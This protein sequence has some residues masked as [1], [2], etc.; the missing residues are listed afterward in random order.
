MNIVIVDT[1]CHAVYAALAC[2]RY[3]NY[4]NGLHRMSSFPI[5]IS[6]VSA[7]LCSRFAKE[8]IRI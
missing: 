4:F 6:F 2:S 1:Y 5:Q 7:V 3:I 8:T